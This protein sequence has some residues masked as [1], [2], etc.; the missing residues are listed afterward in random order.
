MAYPYHTCFTTNPFVYHVRAGDSLHKFGAPPYMC[1]PPP[2]YPDCP[3]VWTD[4]LY[5]TN[6]DCKTNPDGT[7]HMYTTPYTAADG[8]TYTATCT[9]STKQRAPMYFQCFDTTNSNWVYIKPAVT[10]VTR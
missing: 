6:T 7:T 5:W 8:K 3:M 4:G 1:R 2:P 9:Y 10:Q